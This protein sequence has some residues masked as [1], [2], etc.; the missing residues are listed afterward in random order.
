MSRAKREDPVYGDDGANGKSARKSAK[1]V[2]RPFQNGPDPRRGRGPKK[3]APNAGRPTNE[4]RAMV[5]EA[6]ATIAIPRLAQVAA[7]GSDAD[8]V[9]AAAVI[10]DKALPRQI[11]PGDDEDDQVE[12]Y[13]VLPKRA[14]TTREFVKMH[15][16]VLPPGHKLKG[17][18]EEPDTRGS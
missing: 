17:E 2:G 18:L 10:L 6:A 12:W 16:L 15:G 7:K 11:S 3:G 9:R 4:L 5:R 14:R 8:A 1:A 13:V